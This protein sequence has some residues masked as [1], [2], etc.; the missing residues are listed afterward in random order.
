[1]KKIAY[2]LLLFF[3][4]ANTAMAQKFSASASKTKVAVGETFQV[5]FALNASGSNFKMP[6][7]NEF[8]VYSGPNQSTS[9]SFVNGAMSQSITMS[10]I[11][12]PK[13]EGKFTIAPA[14]VNVNGATIQSNSIIIEVVK[15]GAPA[16]QN[17]NN[18]NQQQNI[19]IGEQNHNMKT[20]NKYDDI[21][22]EMMKMNTNMMIFKEMMKKKNNLLMMIKNNDKKK[23]NIN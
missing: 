16:T 18:T 1:M 17:Q 12:A 6:A 14:S 10:Y 9:M 15:G 3:V 11:I 19:E 2:I 4:V 20:D 5:T 23:V 13:K 8:D 22:K 21:I 7:L